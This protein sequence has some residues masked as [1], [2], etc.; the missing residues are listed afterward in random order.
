MK[1]ISTS[2]SYKQYINGE[3]KNYRE[4]KTSVFIGMH[5]LSKFLHKIII[6]YYKALL[7]LFPFSQLITP[8]N[9]YFNKNVLVMLPSL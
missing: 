9:S 7:C 3:R 5:F 1:V 6:G 8:D 2:L 4:Y